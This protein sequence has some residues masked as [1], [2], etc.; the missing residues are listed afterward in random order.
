[1]NRRELT[2]NGTERLVVRIM[3]SAIP[4]AYQGYKK[5]KFHNKTKSRNQIYIP[6]RYMKQKKNSESLTWT[7]LD[8]TNLRHNERF[9]STV[10]T[11]EYRK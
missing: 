9:H 4:C 3:A 2:F 5:E 6:K 1:M 10:T 8:L 11:I 7:E